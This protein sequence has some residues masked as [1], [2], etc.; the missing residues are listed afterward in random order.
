[1]LSAASRAGNIHLKKNKIVPS[2]AVQKI[3]PA[4]FPGGEDSL[5]KFLAKIKWPYTNDNI[6][7]PIKV[8]FYIEKDGS[9]TNFKIEKGVRP[10]F[11]LVALETI[12]KLPDWLPATKSGKTIRS[13][14]IL[15]IDFY[16]EVINN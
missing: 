11:D 10:D 16:I 1:M 13:K 15:P 8:S 7:G 12:K 3:I 2:L 4:K 6:S 14:H 5:K 9:L